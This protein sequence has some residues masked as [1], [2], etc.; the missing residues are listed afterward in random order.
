MEARDIHCG[1][2]RQMRRN[3]TLF[4]CAIASDSVRAENSETRDRPTGHVTPKRTLRGD[5]PPLI[6][7]G[8][9]ATSPQCLVTLQGI[10]VD[11]TY[12]QHVSLTASFAL[13]IPKSLAAVLYNDGMQDGRERNWIQDPN[14]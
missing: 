12:T 1:V 10:L 3:S 8:C 9:D 13:N 11:A 14:S 2:A 7:W 5:L 4:T 6:G